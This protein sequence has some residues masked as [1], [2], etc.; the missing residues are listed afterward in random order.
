M[1]FSDIWVGKSDQSINNEGRQ[2]TAS[3]VWSW[4]VKLLLWSTSWFLCKVNSDRVLLTHCWK[5]LEK[6]V[7][8]TGNRSPSKEPLRSLL[9]SPWTCLSTLSCVSVSLSDSLITFLFLCDGAV[10]VLCCCHLTA[11]VGYR[12]ES[13]PIHRLRTEQPESQ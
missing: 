1:H 3:A 10:T 6:R 4:S 2:H 12:S 8:L 13:E 7:V 5:K 9:R 11:T